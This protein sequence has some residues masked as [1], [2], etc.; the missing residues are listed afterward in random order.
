MKMEKKRRL[1]T[2]EVLMEIDRNSY[3]PAYM[4]L[5][6]LIKQQ[7]AMGM[8]RPGDQL[9]S[10]SQLCSRYHIS[11]MTVRRA[12]NILIDQKI[13]TASQGKG[14]FVTSIKLGSA[15]FHLKELQEFF[16]DKKTTVKILEVRIV[17]SNK[18]T[19]KKLGVKS[20]ESIIY[21][22]RLLL[23]DEEPFFYHKEY[24]IYDPTRPI[25][26]SELE[27][28]SLRGLFNGTGSSEFK[29]GDLSIEATVITREET[30]VLKIQEGVPAFRIEHIFYDFAENPVSWGW[31]IC[32]GD[33]LR[34]TTTVGIR[35]TF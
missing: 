10:E 13:A 32:R 26:E 29:K 9:P 24:L 31:F 35:E 11:P 17:P 19:E 1:P 23:Q 4:Q 25:V 3:E 5:V 6:N 15:A 33:K 27:V 12:I 21:I 20:G 16:M 18:R 30:K 7:I 2:T 22:R 14:T 28:T 34:F 8:F